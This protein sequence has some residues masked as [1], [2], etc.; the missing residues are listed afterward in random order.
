MVIVDAFPG[1]TVLDTSVHVP[2]EPVVPSNKTLVAAH[3]CWSTPPVAGAETSTS[4]SADKGG[5]Q[6]GLPAI[7]HLKL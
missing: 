6:S 2:I 4:T 1:P 7:F 5:A 3:N